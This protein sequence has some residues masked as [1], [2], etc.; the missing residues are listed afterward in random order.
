M[1]KR[2]SIDEDYE[3]NKR[4]RS[5][6]EEET[7][8]ERAL[9]FASAESKD[10]LYKIQE[11]LRKIN[12]KLPDEHAVDSTWVLSMLT[13]LMTQAKSFEEAE[14]CIN[15]ITE[16]FKE[17]E[18]LYWDN[19]KSP[20]IS[21]L[22]LAKIAWRT[23]PLTRENLLMEVKGNSS[24]TLFML[25]IVNMVLAFTKAVFVKPS[26]S[27]FSKRSG[28]SISQ[29]RPG[30]ILCLRPRHRQGLPIIL[31]HPAFLAFQRILRKDLPTSQEAT[32]AMRVSWELCEEMGNAFSEED[33]RSAKFD[34]IMAGMFDGIDRKEETFK[35]LTSHARVDRVYHLQDT[36]VIVREDKNEFETGDAFLY[37]VYMMS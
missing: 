18:D 7:L 36:I 5:T 20:M 35:S 11:L 6:R 17:H 33:A 25:F 2:S 1:S 4:R 31:Y 14:P 27:S 12:G 28:W 10:I 3:P 21:N 34:E 29:E 8:D 26:P 37:C 24:S 19:G 32:Q 30:A 15:E 13:K 9:T 16:Y 23:I 22:K